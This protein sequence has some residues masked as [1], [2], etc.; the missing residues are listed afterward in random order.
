MKGTHTTAI[1]VLLTAT[2]CG[3]G[4]A[5]GD[6]AQ[7]LPENSLRAAASYSTADVDH[8][9]ARTTFGVTQAD[10]D[11]AA[12]MGLPAFVDAMLDFPTTGTSATETAARAYLVNS[13]D[14]IGLEGKFPSTTDITD[15]WLY[16]MLRS[17]HP[18]QERLAMFWHD[19]FA[20]SS[21]ALRAEERYLMVDSIEKLRLQGL[22]NFRTLVLTMARD[23]AMLEWLDG[24]SSVKAEPNENFARE[25]FELFTVGADRGYTEA[26]I[27]EAARAFTG[28]RNRLDPTTNLRVLE[29]DGARKD[30]GAKVLFG[31]VI[32][33]SRGLAGDD[34]D[35]VVDATFAHLDVASWLAEKLLLEFVTDTPSS[36]LITN[37][38]AVIRAADYEMRP[39]LRT[40]FL[41]EAF[42]RRKKEMIRMPVDFGVG[43]VRTTGLMV[44]PEVLRAELLSLAQVPG[45]PPSVF[46]WPQGEQWLSAAGMVERANLVRR[47]I[48]ERTYQTNNG[49]TITMPAGTPDAAAVVDHFA[50]LLSIRLDTTERATLVTYLDT[51]VPSL[52]V[53]QADPFDPNNAQDVSNR[54][55]GLVW[56]LANHP[57]AL[58]R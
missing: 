7:D 32:L 33:Q 2:A 5:A 54:V 30:V 22:G 25:F 45:E 27:Q 29:F 24:S 55:R 46:G 19:H 8:L 44:T 16:L 26:D 9:L 28:Y 36:A 11:R 56:I 48:A 50:S 43:L 1:A 37:L 58:L 38:A 6:S 12:A 53:E 14:P 40:L 10:R 13:T 34:Y 3:G 51:H 35:L 21:V 49:F 23:G 52:G 18:F 31:D 57:D 17:E 4:G 20:I 41:S 39:V 42:H 47:V 15:W